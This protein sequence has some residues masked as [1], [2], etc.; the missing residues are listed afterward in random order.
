MR[1]DILSREDIKMVIDN[2]Y[3]QIKQDKLIGY[4]FN[5]IA[6]VNWETHLPIM[7][8]FWESTVLGTVEFKRNVM[9]PHIL[10][11]EKIALK[12]EFFD[13][14]MQLFTQTINAF[15]AGENAEAM[16][17]RAKNIS[18]VMQHKLSDGDS[19]RLL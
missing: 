16:K 2:F 19:K 14:W 12:P 18:A 6:Q 15:Y 13:R 3:A 7:Y 10:L 17:S 11:N 5:E 4:I 8:D 1:A 9:L